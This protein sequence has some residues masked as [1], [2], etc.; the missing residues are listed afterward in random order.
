MAFTKKKWLKKKLELLLFVLEPRNIIYMLVCFYALC[1]SIDEAQPCRDLEHLCISQLDQTIRSVGRVIP[2]RYMFFLS[3]MI[4]KYSVRRRHT[5]QPKIYCLKNT[6]SH[7][8]QSGKHQVCHRQLCPIFTCCGG[9]LTKRNIRFSKKIFFFRSHMV[10][11]KAIIFFK[12]ILNL[13]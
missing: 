10:Y 12:C 11:A 9:F 6:D 13:R 7:R 8:I 2:N 3:A 1:R 5:S 4:L